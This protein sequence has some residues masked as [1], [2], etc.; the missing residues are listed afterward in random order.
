MDG[1][2]IQREIL[3]EAIIDGEEKIVAVESL[4]EEILQRAATI[5][6]QVAS[7]KEF[8]AENQQ[9]AEKPELLLANATYD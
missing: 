3:E 7:L 8:I 5:E 9:T 4:E 1:F 6:E 2:R